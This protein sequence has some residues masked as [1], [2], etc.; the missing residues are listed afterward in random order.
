[1]TRSRYDQFTIDLGAHQISDFTGDLISNLN[2]LVRDFP[3]MR[4]GK[5]ITGTGNTNAGEDPPF[6]V[7]DWSRDGVH[8]HFQLFERR[9][10]ATRAYLV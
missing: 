8:S 5:T 6:M 7:V 4:P 9:G 2:N 10:V 3:N 1:M